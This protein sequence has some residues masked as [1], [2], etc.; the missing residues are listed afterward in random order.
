[1]IVFDLSCEHG[2]RFEGWFSSSDDYAAQIDE[3]LLACPLCGS[4]K[5]AKAPM[6]P[7]VGKK[8]NQEAASAPKTDPAPA[9][10][11]ETPRPVSN[12][13]M[14]PEV[15]AALEKLAE[16]QN[17]ALKNSKWVGKNFAEESRAMHYGERDHAPIHGEAS[18]EEA[19]ELLDEGVPVA[20]LP[21]PVAPPDDLN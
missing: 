7:S 4:G 5:V 10:Q 21:F 13:P 17:K 15:S 6:A 9:V 8:G 20:P 1:M 16:A 12:A 18:A 19:K 14:P 11:D 2:H 3:D